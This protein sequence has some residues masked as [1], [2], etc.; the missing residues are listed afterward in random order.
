MQPK[1]LEL[2]WVAIL[3]GV[4]TICSE[5]RKEGPMR[6]SMWHEQRSLSQ[7][8]RGKKCREIKS[9]WDQRVSS[10]YFLKP[11]SLRHSLS[12][13]LRKLPWCLLCEEEENAQLDRESDHGQMRKE[14]NFRCLPGLSHM[15][16]WFLE[17]QWSCDVT[18][19]ISCHLPADLEGLAGLFSSLPLSHLGSAP[20]LWCCPRGTLEVSSQGPSTEWPG[21]DLLIPYYKCCIFLTSN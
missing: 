10:D 3:D 2:N 20:G 9:H 17:P 8:R 16:F 5:C 1:M 15:W 19:C 12:N 7:K 13:F 14:G 4:L 6:P 18:N 11:L 21:S